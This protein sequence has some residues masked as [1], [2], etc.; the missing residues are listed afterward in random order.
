MSA[1]IARELPPLCL[2]FFL[3]ERV[4][5]PGAPSGLSPRGWQ[6]GPEHLNQL[7]AVSSQEALGDQAG[8]LTLS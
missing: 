7:P 5:Q 6:G 1:R 4:K 8:D 3:F 2:L